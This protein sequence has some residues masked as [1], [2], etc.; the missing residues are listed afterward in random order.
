MLIRQLSDYKLAEPAT[1][2]SYQYFHFFILGS[3]ALFRYVSRGADVVK[4]VDT[5]ARVVYDYAH[6]S[7]AEYFVKWTASIEGRTV[8]V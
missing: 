3:S 7:S 4:K 2:T 6:Y 8:N 5:S 1:R